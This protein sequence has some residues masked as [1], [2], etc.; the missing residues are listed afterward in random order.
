MSAWAND[1]QTH[2]EASFVPS[3]ADNQHDFDAQPEEHVVA[4]HDFNS[5]NATCLSFQAGQVIK[6][7][8]RDPSGWW[9]GELDGQR[10]VSEQLCRPGGGL[11]LG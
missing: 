5:N 10:A 9:D 3:Y 6:V 11:R 8:N 4:L 2:S 7:Y 1:V